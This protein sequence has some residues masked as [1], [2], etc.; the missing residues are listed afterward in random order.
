MS[1]DGHHKSDGSE[2]K[3]VALPA[4]NFGV[5]IFPNPAPGGMFSVSVQ[6]DA[7]SKV[8][9]SLFDILGRMVVSLY[10]GPMRDETRIFEISRIDLPPGM[11]AIAVST[12]SRTYGK[13]FIVQ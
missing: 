7:E 6:G 10:E 1:L 13:S 9:V 8:S 3:G 2:P 12:Q 4:G 11:Y 5:D